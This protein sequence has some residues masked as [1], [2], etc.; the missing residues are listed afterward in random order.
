M[1][2][3]QD[4]ELQQVRAIAESVL[5]RASTDEAY[6]ASLRADPVAVLAAA[7]LSDVD[8]RQIG[9]DEWQYEEV[10]GFKAKECQMTCDRWTCKITICGYVPLTG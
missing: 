3:D 10:S 5:A 7:G 2:D 8:A 1:S 6:L 4:K 9:L